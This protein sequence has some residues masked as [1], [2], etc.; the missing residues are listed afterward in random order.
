[1]K[2]ES[3]VQ[4][5]YLDH[6]DSLDLE[7]KSDRR[8]ATYTIRDFC[9]ELLTEL[10]REIYSVEY[11]Y[12]ERISTQQYRLN[13]IIRSSIRIN[14]SDEIS[15][16]PRNIHN[17]ANSTKH[18]FLENPSK[19]DLQSHRQFAEEWRNW[20]I[21]QAKRYTG[22]W[23]KTELSFSDD[24]LQDMKYVWKNDR[25]GWILYITEPLLPPS[26]GNS[27]WLVYNPN[28]DTIEPISHQ[29][30]DNAETCRL[31]RY[32]RINEALE[33]AKQFMREYD[34]PPAALRMR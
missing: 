2:L 34:K 22:K 8:L 17:L 5:D 25:T 26:E 29:K 12:E 7:N 3:D 32:K 21:E 31:F 9:G 20:H 24:I 11:L 10:G 30:L 33:I 1:M 13:D 6:F 28:I 14:I 4:Q 18:N 27:A 16:F 23:R 19:D 15:E